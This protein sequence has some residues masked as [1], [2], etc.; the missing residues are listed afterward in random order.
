MSSRD[1]FVYLCL[2]NTGTMVLPRSPITSSWTGLDELSEEELA[3]IDPSLLPP[4]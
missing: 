1:F 2:E 4:G 3:E